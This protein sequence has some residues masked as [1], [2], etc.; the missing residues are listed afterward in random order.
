[1]DYKE[2]LTFLIDKNSSYYVKP[3]FLYNLALCEI[4][5]Q[6]NGLPSLQL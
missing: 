1:M 5:L 4:S 2:E 3:I 6:T